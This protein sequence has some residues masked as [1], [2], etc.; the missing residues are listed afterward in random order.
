M[1]GV[2]N[3][4][5]TASWPASSGNEEGSTAQQPLDS[6]DA[7]DA[8]RYNRPEGDLGPMTLTFR[9]HASANDVQVRAVTFVHSWSTAPA[10][11]PL[12]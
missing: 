11:K 12:R 9:R 8:A 2:I 4:S 10:R 6:E 7:D 3:A 5:Y 1:T